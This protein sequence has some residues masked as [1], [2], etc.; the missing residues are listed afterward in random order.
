[1]NCPSIRP[2]AA[3]GGADAEMRDL[4]LAAIPALRAFAYSL[5]YN[6]DRSDDL[7]QDTLVRAWTKAESFQRGTNLTAWL[8]TI[9]RNLF[10][11]EQRK[12]KRE[13]EDA[14]GVH[15]GRLTSLP[16]QEIRVEMR[17]FQTALDTLPLSQREALVLVGA[18]SF[19]YE[20]AAAICGV[21]VGTMKSRVS[22]ARGRL[23]ETLGMTGTDDIGADALTRAAAGS[24]P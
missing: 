20:E 9:L 2:P 3:P 5:T 13:V 4:L 24:A 1:M 16:E 11:S 22:R 7:V 21:A 6:L 8:F 10:Y 17:E 14:E 12:R 19:T 15:A 18:Q 23:I